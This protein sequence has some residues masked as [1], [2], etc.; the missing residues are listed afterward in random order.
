MQP[1]FKYSYV[2]H[3]NDKVSGGVSAHPFWCFPTAKFKK[4][5]YPFN[6]LPESLTFQFLST[7]FKLVSV[8]PLSAVKG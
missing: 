5:L 6:T 8:S 2:F 3:L 1:A 7:H 4:E